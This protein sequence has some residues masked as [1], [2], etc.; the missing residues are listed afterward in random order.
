MKTRKLVG[1]YL[2]QRWRDIPNYE[3]YYRCSSLGK[4]KSLGRVI[5]R[6]NGEKQHIKERILKQ[7]L[8][9]AGYCVVNLGKKAIQKIYYIHKLVAIVFLNHIP[10][11]HKLVVDHIDGYKFKNRV[12]NLHI[13]TSRENLSTCFRKNKETLS[14]KFV[15]V[16]WENFSGKWRAE[17]H[18]NNKKKT[19]GRFTSEQEA[20]NAY[21]NT[22]LQ[23]TEKL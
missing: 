22:L 8:T 20:S 19:L 5:T 9:L 15:G 11:G 18:M 4:V 10:D 7:S 17:I 23:F 16:C 12:S 21:Q 1:G 13:V 6:I 3:G 2:W 14:S